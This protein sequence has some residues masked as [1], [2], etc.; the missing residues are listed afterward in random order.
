MQAK[1]LLEQGAIECLVD[2]QLKFTPKNS[3]Q[4]ARMVEAAAACINSE[5]SRRPDIDQI[6]TIIRG[7]QPP[8][9]S[10]LRKSC[11]P[12][13][14]SVIGNPLFQQT[15]S[16]MNSHLALAMVGVSEFEDD[17]LVYCR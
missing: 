5:E 12:S 7:E 15:K 16:E 14:G 9:T 3:K 4:I 11:F 13:S 2:P 1:P 17:D 8:N 10:T 6:I